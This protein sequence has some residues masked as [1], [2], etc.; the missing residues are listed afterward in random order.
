MSYVFVYKFCNRLFVHLFQTISINTH[1]TFS[2]VSPYILL[3]FSHW[4][5]TNPKHL[6]LVNSPPPRLNVQ[7]LYYTVAS[8]TR[9]RPNNSKL[10][11]EK[12][13][14]PRKICGRK[15]VKFVKKPQKSSRKQVLVKSCTYFYIVQTKTIYLFYNF[16]F[17]EWCS[18][19]FLPKFD[20]PGVQKFVCN[21][22]NLFL[23][24]E[25]KPCSDLATVAV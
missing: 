14:W 2:Y 18:S 15:L 12:C 17:I 10:A 16:I 21:W 23:K 22:P 6:S 4:S 24:F 19:Y 9:F 11:V 13:C 7:Q 3:L 20:F 25:G 1:Y 5:N 8:R